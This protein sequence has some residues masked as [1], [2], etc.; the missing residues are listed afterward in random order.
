VTDYGLP[1]RN[2]LNSSLDR[3]TFGLKIA[4]TSI[5]KTD[6]VNPQQFVLDP[7]SSGDL[8]AKMKQDPQAGLKQAAQQFEGMLLQMMLKSMR[9]ASP[10]DGLLDSDQSR[11]FTGI[12]DQQ[13]AQ[14]LSAQGKLGF[15]KMIEQQLGRNLTPGTTT[16]GV[17]ASSASNTDTSTGTTSALNALQQAFI[18]RQAAG[19]A[20]PLPTPSVV[21][22]PS[23]AKDGSTIQSPAKIA[24][25]KPGSSSDFVNRV[26]PYAQE[27][28]AATGCLLNSWSLTPRWRVVGVS[29][30]SARPMARPPITCSVSRRGVVGKAKR[31]IPRRPSLRTVSPSRRA[32]N[33]ASIPPMPKPLA[34]TP[35]C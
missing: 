20:K 22:S 31:S 27:A 6:S 15:A 23:E 10:Q 21:L 9:D 24:T 35:V 13:L 19:L 16:P 29:T 1:V 4:H 18:S 8:R 2:S 5:M 17:S 7:K 25:S 12:M 14:N 34:T 28:A 32:K 33:S 11:F 26:W 30:K 3:W